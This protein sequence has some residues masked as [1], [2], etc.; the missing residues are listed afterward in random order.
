[1]VRQKGGLY[2]YARGPLLLSGDLWQ[3]PELEGTYRL[4]NVSSPFVSIIQTL[5]SLLQDPPCGNSRD[6]RREGCMGEL[7]TL[8]LMIPK[9]RQTGQ[10][11]K[12]HWPRP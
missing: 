11:H 3:Q 1:M 7:M 6:E 10:A 12:A 5:D 2:S 4:A 9:R 8:R